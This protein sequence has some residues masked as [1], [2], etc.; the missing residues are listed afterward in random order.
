[1]GLLLQFVLLVFLITLA[2]SKV[3]GDSSQ[4]SNEAK[5]DDVKDLPTSLKRHGSALPPRSETR[6]DV[7]IKPNNSFTRFLTPQNGQQP[8]EAKIEKLKQ[9]A[10]EKNSVVKN[11]QNNSV[12]AVQKQHP[13]QSAVQKNVPGNDGHSGIPLAIQQV[14]I[15]IWDRMTFFSFSYY[16]EVEFCI[17][18]N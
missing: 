8:E 4:Q 13:Q 16:V 9:L 11:G 15:I 5:F 18:V 7:K 1:M 14:I 17:S 2:L 12:D 10:L 3:N 6:F